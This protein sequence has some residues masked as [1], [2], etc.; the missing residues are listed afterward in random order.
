MKRFF[1]IFMIA[2]LMTS[3]LSA[4]GESEAEWVGD[5]FHPNEYTY[6][7]DVSRFG[8]PRYQLFVVDGHGSYV[9]DDYTENCE[10]DSVLIAPEIIR[11]S[12][13]CGT[14]ACDLFIDVG[15]H[16]VTEEIYHVI[17]AEDN[18]CIYIDYE[19]NVSYVVIREIFGEILLKAEID[20]ATVSGFVDEVKKI[21]PNT[22]EIAFVNSLFENE[23]VKI[24]FI[25]DTGFDVQ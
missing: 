6:V 10:P 2:V 24:S 19:D 21:G 4:V 15:T 3:Y 12:L 17:Y 16:R 11:I 1:L 22:Y 23:R 8:K 13:P 5:I 25:Q 9:Y 18:I 7:Y 14:V 20:L